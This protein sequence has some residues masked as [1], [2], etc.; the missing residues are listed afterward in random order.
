MLSGFG[1][2]MSMMGGLGN[3][4]KLAK[5]YKSIMEELKSETVQAGSGGDMVVATADG[6]GELVD[7][8]INPQLVKDGDVEMLEDLVKSAVTAV[9]TKS[10]DA[11]QQKLGGLAGGLPL[12]KLKGLLGG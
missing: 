11:M 9:V 2:M 4:G 8:K 5:Q 7:L 10:K 1:D 12:D 6:L 3:L